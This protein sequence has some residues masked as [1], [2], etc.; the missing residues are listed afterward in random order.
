MRNMLNFGL[1]N[2]P[3]LTMLA[4]K[5]AASSRNSESHASGVKMIDSLL[6]IIYNNRSGGCHPTIKIHDSIWLRLQEVRK[7]SRFG[8]LLEIFCAFANFVL[9]NASIGET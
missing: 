7:L 4:R 9:Q 5:V 2:S 8:A 3:I 1:R 6:C